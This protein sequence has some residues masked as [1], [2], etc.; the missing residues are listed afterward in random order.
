MQK[1]KLLSP[2]YLNNPNSETLPQAAS[3]MKHARTLQLSWACW[4]KLPIY[5]V[6]Q[7]GK[8]VVLW[9]FKG[10]TGQTRKMF[11]RAKPVLHLNTEILSSCEIHGKQVS[12]W[13]EKFFFL[14][15]CLFVKYQ[16]PFLSFLSGSDLWKNHIG[17]KCHSVLIQTEKGRHSGYSHGLADLDPP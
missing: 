8:G 7:W 3:A 2:S 10:P 13:T 17:I 14:I 6:A 1:R 11:K 5:W 4:Q 12:M 9:H 16:L 15:Q